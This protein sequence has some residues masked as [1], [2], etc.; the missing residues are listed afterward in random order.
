MTLRIGIDARLTHYRTGGI[1]TYIRGLLAAF[2]AHPPPDADIIVLH[3]RKQ[4]P[5]LVPGLRHAAL[6]TP[7]HHRLEKWALS[8]EL[9]R[10]RL[11][12]LHS[13][14]FIPPVRGARRH[15]ITVH[16]LAFLH[17][18]DI[19]T[20]D[21]KRYYADQ[22][23][24]A[25]GHADGILTVSRAT[26]DD[27]TRLLGVPSAKLTPQVEGVDARFRPLPP[28][29]VAS[30]L[31]KFGLERGY[32]LFVG[33]I[34]PRKNLPTLLDAYA[35]LRATDPSTPPLVVVG[36]AGWL[37]DATLARLR[38]AEG[39][40]HIPDASDDDL[41]ALYNGAALLTVPSHYEGFG[42][43][44][45]E[46]MACGTL[47]VVSNRSSLPEVVGE[48]GLL[49]DPDDPR[50][51]RDALAFALAQPLAWH[52][53]Q[54]EAA[55]ARAAQFTWAQAAQTALDLYRKAADR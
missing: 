35:D 40:Q 25:V 23:R 31:S 34:E 16:D 24:W 6:W 43:T 51:L 48:V 41:P 33:T 9:A 39:V 15:V 28:E 2:S 55:L 3:S 4:A 17:Y 53:H 8:F 14:D 11:D 26:A 32:L 42:L 30:V 5:P 36:R 7:C 19:L 44:A 29:Q 21:S 45:L 12:V 18:P 54:R 38:Q 20:A 46:A 52:A 13:P 49:I 50:T 37:A 47:P 22:I 10:L 1:S 27:L